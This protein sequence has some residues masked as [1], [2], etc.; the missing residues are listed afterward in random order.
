MEQLNEDNFDFR[1]FDIQNPEGTL[2]SNEIS[3]I[4]T[5]FR[6]LEA[7]LYSLDLPIKIS[8][9]EGPSLEPYT[10]RLRGT[11]YHHESEK[12][13][14]VQF[15][16]DLPLCRAN[17]NDDGSMAAFSTESIDFGTIAHQEPSHRFVIL[18][19]LNPTQK[20]KFDF[21][22]QKSNLVWEDELAIEP[23]RGEL[24]PNSHCNIKMTCIPGKDFCNFEG[25]IQCSIDWES[26]GR[27]IDEARSVA[28]NTAVPEVSEFLFI[29]LKKRARIVSYLQVMAYLP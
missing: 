7:K 9:I 25:E 14:E 5:K 22:F 4:Y 12:P 17:L 19:N 13:E 29:R 20:L 1:V 6:P 2:K 18:Y 27:N 16:E 10:L 8:D 28:T 11:G 26:E 24:K 23:V 3:Y 21:D 15:Y